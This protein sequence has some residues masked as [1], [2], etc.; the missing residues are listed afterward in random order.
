M[1]CPKQI[2]IIVNGPT[3]I[4]RIRLNLSMQ[5]L[6]SLC[7]FHMLPCLAAVNLLPVLC[8]YAV[9]L[10]ASAYCSTSMVFQILGQRLLGS[11]T[12]WKNRGYAIQSQST[13]NTF[14]NTNGIASPKNL[15]E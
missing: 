4:R 10:N 12:P 1:C 7:C 8:R 15:E 5:A 14:N 2:A 13:L 11:V 9:F 6:E 3:R